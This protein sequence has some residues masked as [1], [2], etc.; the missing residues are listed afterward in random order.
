MSC[1]WQE[2]VS[3]WFDGELAPRRRAEVDA[4]LRSCRDCRRLVRQF[5]ELQRI[6]MQAPLPRA[7]PEL[8]DAAMASVRARTDHPRWFWPSGRRMFWPQFSLAFSGLAV[9]SFLA[10]VMLRD[11]TGLPF[12]HR[13]GSSSQVTDGIAPVTAAPEALPQ[14]AAPIS[15]ASAASEPGAPPVVGNLI[16]DNTATGTERLAAL[17]RSLGGRVDPVT[18]PA[19]STVY[20]SLPP[21]ERALFE[22]R[23]PEIG[24]WRQ[25]TPATG[26]PEAVFGVRIIQQTVK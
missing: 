9:A 21:S 18:R 24:Q 20:V 7:R 5:R 3:A 15:A 14:R 23:L 19:Q 12:F 10:V 6:A 2:D 1:Q 17:A 11:S 4:H 13:A 25:S 22:E 8:T 26:S 16:V